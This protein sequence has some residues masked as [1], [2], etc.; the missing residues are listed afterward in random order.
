MSTCCAN[1]ANIEKLCGGGNAAGMRTKLYITC[2]DQVSSIPAA[3]AKVISSDI[4][5]VADVGDGSAGVF[6]EINISKNNQNYV[7]EP[8]GDD[9][10]PDY[11]HTLTFNILKMTAAKNVVIDT[12][13]GAECIVIWYDRNGVPWI[14]G[15]L[16]EGASFQ[17][18]PQ[19]NDINAYACTINWRSPQTL[20]SY[21]G[22][23]SAAA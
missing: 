12:L 3:T 20:D 9:E 5:M 13:N 21:T 19:T 11:N 6:Y 23:I 16:T 15:S 22:T 14:M 18:S 8:Q 10:N 17:A 2:V 7:G 4:T 1:L